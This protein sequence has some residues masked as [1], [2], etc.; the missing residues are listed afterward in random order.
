MIDPISKID[1][2]RNLADKLFGGFGID[3]DPQGSIGFFVGGYYNFTVNPQLQDYQKR[4]C[5]P[6]FDTDIRMDLQGSIGDKLKLN[7]NFDT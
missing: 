3:I 7:A 6:D 5:G 2:K 4:Q 1:I